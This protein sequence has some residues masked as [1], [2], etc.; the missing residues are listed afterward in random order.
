[1][2]TKTKEK[3]LNVGFLNIHGQSKMTQ[4]KQDQIQYL[5]KEYELDVLN[6]QETNIDESTFQKS[7]FIAN[8]FKIIFKNNESGY[9]VCSLVRNELPTK[10]EIQHPS[11]RLIAFDIGDLTMTNVYLPS[12]GGEARDQRENFFGQT[13]PNTL[14]SAR[15][16][17]ICGG[18]FNSITHP[19]DCTHNPEAKMSPNLKKLTRILSWQD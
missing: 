10:N 13:I 8:N 17:G 11:G 18:D 2:D 5:I 16:N 19:I 1:M 12:G 3:T 14:L 6:L 7:P 4:S 15:K 9:G